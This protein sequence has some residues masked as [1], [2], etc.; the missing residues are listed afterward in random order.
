MHPL[1]FKAE[2]LLHRAAALVGVRPATRLLAPF[3]PPVAGRMA[4]MLRAGD[5]DTL[6]FTLKNLHPDARPGAIEAMLDILDDGERCDRWIDRLRAWYRQSREFHAT[7]ACLHGLVRYAWQK[8]SRNEASLLPAHCG[9]ACRDACIDAARLLDEALAEQADNAGLLCLSLAVART[10]AEPVAV[11]AERFE[12]L[13]AVAP[14][15][16]PGHHAMLENLDP[17]WGG[18]DGALLDFARPSAAAAPDGHPLCALAARAHLRRYLRLRAAGDPEVESFFLDPAV[19]ADIEAG[20]RRSVASPAFRD[21]I[22]R[23]SLN[24]LF[25]AMLFLAGHVAHARLALAALDGSC[26]AEPWQAL[27]ATPRE[28]AHPGWVVDRVQAVL[29]MPERDFES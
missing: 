3:V 16:V 15:H 11:S 5:H 2:V 18:S 12:H 8:R 20:W 6:R 13:C 24:N 4:S 23:D 14:L 1:R 19:S 10:C 29:A 25:A 26:L 28:A 27:A 22:W 21:E 17:R 9:E 7:T